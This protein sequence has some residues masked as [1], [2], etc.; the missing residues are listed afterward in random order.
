MEMMPERQ[1]YADDN[2]C[3]TSI[4]SEGESRRP[5]RYTVYEISDNDS[6]Y[7]NQP[8]SR[9]AEY[10]P[11]PQMLWIDV[12]GL[13]DANVFSGSYL[14]D[15]MRSGSPSWSDGN[16][17][18]RQVRGR[19]ELQENRGEYF[20]IVSDE[21][22]NNRLPHEMT[23]WSDQS[24]FPCDVNIRI[25]YSQQIQFPLSPNRSTPVPRSRS[26]TQWIPEDWNAP[27]IPMSPIDTSGRGSNLV[28]DAHRG[29]TPTLGVPRYVRFVG[30]AT[31]GGKATPLSGV[32]V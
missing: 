11:F 19:W 6:L 3:Y 32:A 21:R 31:P 4:S 24:G 1:C 5:R 13:N 25:D 2:V 10:H 27:I 7:S 18:L 8:L 16:R 29:E 14:F 15:G 26:R 9:G 20:K 17:T 30:S 23:S 28:F 12:D 22:H